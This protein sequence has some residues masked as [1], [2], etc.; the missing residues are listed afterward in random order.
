MLD[1]ETPIPEWRQ[2][3]AVSAALLCD[4]RGKK[5]LTA[6][7]A[8]KVTRGSTRDSDV[9]SRFPG[10]HQQ[11]ERHLLKVHIHRCKH[12]SFNGLVASGLPASD[13]STLVLHG[14]ADL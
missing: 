4:L 10:V 5:N 13:F 12:R 3:F 6:E 7:S 9:A 8:E 1:F 2:F 11:T 14:I